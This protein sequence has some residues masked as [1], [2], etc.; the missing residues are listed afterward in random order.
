MRFPF[1]VIIGPAI[2]LGVIVLTGLM[3]I[4]ALRRGTRSIQENLEKQTQSESSS[5]PSESAN[6]RW[7]RGDMEAAQQ[8]PRTRTKMVSCPTCGGENPTGASVCSFCGRE[9]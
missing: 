2:C 7:A 8:P 5:K 9:L 4:F 6:T 3:L 1:W